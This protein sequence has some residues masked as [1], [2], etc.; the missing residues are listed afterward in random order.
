MIKGSLKAT[1][2]VTLC[3]PFTY[4]E[5]VALLG[6]PR[7][8]KGAGL[9]S[10]ILTL[11]HERLGFAQ[12]IELARVLNEGNLPVCVDFLTV[13]ERQ[14]RGSFAD[15]IKRVSSENRGHPRST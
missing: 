6:G 2:G 9:T 4:G 11:V 7:V 3:V 8:Q 12:S 14:Q 10:C 5:A 13:E 1:A 15:F